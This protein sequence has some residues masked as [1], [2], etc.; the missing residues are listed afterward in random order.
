MKPILQTAL[1]AAFTLAAALPAAAQEKSW[2]GETVVPIKPLEKIQFGDWVGDE[3]VY[4]P[5][6]EVFSFRVR[7]ER[8]GWLRIHD[9]WVDKADFLLQREA[10]AYFNRRVQENPRDAF[11]LYVRGMCRVNDNDLDNA[12]KDFDKCVRLG[13]AA[14]IALTARG[15]VWGAKMDFDKAIADCNEAIRLNPK[16]ARAYETRAAI[17]RDVL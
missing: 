17:C 1:L 15:N 12:I 9:G 13:S 5:L 7:A 6:G 16:Y 14:W 11:A 8:D 2:T 3:Q 10:T 4:F